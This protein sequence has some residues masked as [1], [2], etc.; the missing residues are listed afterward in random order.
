MKH[1]T[2]FDSSIDPTIPSINSGLASATISPNDSF[3]SLIMRG[4]AQIELNALLI[5]GSQLLKNVIGVRGNEL[6]IKLPVLESGK[7]YEFSWVVY[8]YTN[9]I[10]IGA[11]IIHKKEEHFLAHKRRLEGGKFWI[12][13][14]HT[15]RA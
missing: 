3:F 13:N 14:T 9:I 1:T 7:K 15:F 10:K 5:N 2:I 11:Y 6:T 12:P 4:P 8:G